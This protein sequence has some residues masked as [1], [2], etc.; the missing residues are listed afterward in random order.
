LGVPCDQL[1]ALLWLQRASAGGSPLA[2][3]FLGKVRAT[4]TPAQIA[5]AERH[6]AASLPEPVI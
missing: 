6:A 1:A 4:L 3:Q 2:E 5:D